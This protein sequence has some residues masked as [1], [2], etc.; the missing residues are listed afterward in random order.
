MSGAVPP[1]SAFDG[2]GETGRASLAAGRAW[3]SPLQIGQMPAAASIV[4]A[5]QG[6]SFVAGAG[7][8]AADGV[9]SITGIGGAVLSAGKGAYSVP[10]QPG[11]EIH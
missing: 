9:I 1:G 4:S 6:Q 10:L 2:G 5:H 8:A 11:Q 3:A 7:S